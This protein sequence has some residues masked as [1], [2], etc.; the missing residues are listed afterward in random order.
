MLLCVS[1][2]LGMCCY[3]PAGSCSN[4]LLCFYLA[5]FRVIASRAADNNMY[6]VKGGIAV[7][8]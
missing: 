7:S 5:S 8:N 4:S 1:L 2:T 3:M 6:G